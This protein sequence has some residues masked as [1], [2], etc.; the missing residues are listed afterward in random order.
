LAAARRT[1]APAGTVPPSHFGGYPQKFFVS[2][3][4]GGFEFPSTCAEVTCGMK[5][6]SRACIV[7]L[8]LAMTA[9][10]DF[11]VYKGNYLTKETSAEPVQNPPARTYTVYR[12]IDL[13]GKKFK[14]ITYQGKGI[15]RSFQRGRAF[16]LTISSVQDPNK[17]TKE[18]TVA[19]L[20]TTEPNFSGTGAT[21]VSS[22]LMKGLNSMVPISAISIATAPKTLAYTG[23]SLLEAG[24]FE[25]S[26][27]AA[28]LY[29]TKGRFVLQSLLSQKVNNETVSFDGAVEVVAQELIAKG[30]TDT[31]GPAN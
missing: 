22:L 18:F 13:A 14:D 8:G 10:A 20:A 24:S 11:A 15:S 4:F 19:A 27:F 25:G 26:P 29:E 23:Y 3:P 28:S 5:I 12:I 9:L 31:S 17:A 30:Y 21:A 2:R 16:D 1:L 6:L 7:S